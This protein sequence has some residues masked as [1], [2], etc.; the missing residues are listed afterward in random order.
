[1]TKPAL[2]TLKLMLPLSAYAADVKAAPAKASNAMRLARR[3]DKTGMDGCSLTAREDANRFSHL[4][5]YCADG[6]STNFP[7]SVARTGCPGFGPDPSAHRMHRGRKYEK[8]RRS[9]VSAPEVS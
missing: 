7:A 2:M 9:G 4:A 6:Q 3:A 8:L 5:P 1:M